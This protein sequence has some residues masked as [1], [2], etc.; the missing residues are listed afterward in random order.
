VLAVCLCLTGP[1]PA[2][3]A[4]SLTVTPTENTVVFRFLGLR[5]CDSVVA[6]ATVIQWL[7]P[8]VEVVVRRGTKVVTRGAWLACTYRQGLFQPWYH[9]PKASNGNWLPIGRKNVL[10]LRADMPSTRPYLYRYLVTVNGRRVR[11][12]RI[13]V[14]VPASGAR[15]IAV[16]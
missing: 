10:T 12:G 1:S 14:V 9:R 15:R 6:N 7:G 5:P 16:T 3:A 4:V 11:S 2:R 8:Q 13:H